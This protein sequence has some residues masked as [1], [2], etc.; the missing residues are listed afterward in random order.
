MVVQN[1]SPSLTKVEVRFRAKK[2]CLP[3]MALFTS[4]LMRL[5]LRGN[6]WFWGEGRGISGLYCSVCFVR[7]IRAFVLGYKKD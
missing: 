7:L 4:C 1:Q 2:L 3:A 6:A 5:G